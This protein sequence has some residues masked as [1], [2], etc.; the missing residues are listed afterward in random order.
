MSL[1]AAQISSVLTR[2]IS[3]TTSRAT[4]NVSSPTR[5]TA[6]PSANVPTRSSVNGAPRFS[7][8][9]MLAD[10][11]GCTPMTFTPGNRFFR[12]APTPQIRPPPPTGTNTASGTRGHCRSSSIAIVPWP[13]MHVRVVERVHER[14]VLRRGELHRVRVRVVEDAAFEHDLAAERGDGVDLDRRRAGRHH[15]HGAHAALARRERHALR[16]VTGRAADH[17][18]GERV[19]R[20]MRDPVVGAAQ[21]ER[22]HGLQVLAL[23]QHLVAEPLRQARCTVERRFDRD[24]VHAR[25]CDQRCIARGYGVGLSD[26][27]HETLVPS[28]GTP[29]YSARPGA[30]SGAQRAATCD[31]P[32]GSGRA[33][34][35]TRGRCRVTSAAARRG[36]NT[37]A[38][39]AA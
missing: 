23:Q 26:R 17:A 18:L 20:Q 22:E 13:A 15:D 38:C 27:A 12:C 9:Y 33:S 34:A 32:P 3:S 1:I 2:M 7:D 8:S 31:A 29:V 5:R 6:T 35:E 14:E 25:A 37:P 30:V 16:M 11:S 19:R 36:A 4:R 39:T 28:A 24:V 21:L 10:S